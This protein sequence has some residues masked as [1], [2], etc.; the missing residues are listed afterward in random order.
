MCVS[1]RAVFECGVLCVSG[2]CLLCLC[3]VVAVFVCV[4][5][6]LCV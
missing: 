2:V 1:V 3:V 6:C 4:C 5:V